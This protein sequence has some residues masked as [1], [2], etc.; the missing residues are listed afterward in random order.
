MPVAHPG[1]SEEGSKLKFAYTYLLYSGQH[2]VR[3]TNL[4]Y[5]ELATMLQA[6]SVPYIA[7]RNFRTHAAKTQLTSVI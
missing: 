2:R 4:T 6:S 5:K 7:K 1:Y 3:N